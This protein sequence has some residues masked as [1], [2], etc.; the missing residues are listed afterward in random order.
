MTR[1]A[2]MTV[3]ILLKDWDDQANQG[4]RDRID[5]AVQTLEGADGFIASDF[6]E[7]PV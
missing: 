3:A 5:T 1:L 7:T 2:L 4:F 6:D